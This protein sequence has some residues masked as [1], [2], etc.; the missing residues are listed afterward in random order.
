[1][2]DG[3]RAFEMRVRRRYW[4]LIVMFDKGWC[5]WDR[6]LTSEKSL[7]GCGGKGTAVEVKDK[8]D[9]V[10]LESNWEAMSG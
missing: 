3:R 6:C 7:D 5:Q 1:M 10:L 9:A 4:K 8:W 2:I